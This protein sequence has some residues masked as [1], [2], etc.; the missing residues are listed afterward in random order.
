MIN[1]EGRLFSEGGTNIYVGQLSQQS[2]PFISFSFVFFFYCIT[3]YSF[4][5]IE[6]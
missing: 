6:W 2:V 4:V 1:S 3:I 5:I